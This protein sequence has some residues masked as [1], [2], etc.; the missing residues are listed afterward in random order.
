MTSNS[1]VTDLEYCRT[2]I[3]EIVEMSLQR[4]NKLLADKKI[5]TKEYLEIGDKCEIPLRRLAKDLTI[6]I[7]DGT[8]SSM[9][10]LKSQIDVVKGK[11]K[12][13]IT[14][15]KNFNQSITY[16]SKV[17]TFFGS[18]LNAASTGIIGIPN[19]LDKIENILVQNSP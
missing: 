17:I 6:K 15:I 14:E 4:R 3:Y 12:K 19:L 7:F 13:V 18:V 16:F 5:S 8:I 9:E 2:T 1:D 10:A 11:L